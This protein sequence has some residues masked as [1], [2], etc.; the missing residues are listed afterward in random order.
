MAQPIPRVS[1]VIPTRNRQ[2]LLLRTLATVL[3]QEGVEIAVVVVD[4]ASSDGTPEALA[5][6]ADGRVS[7]VRHDVAQGV[8]AA[9]NA[10]LRE[11]RTE[12]VAFV[13][14]DD[15]WAP[16]KLA[17]QLA[18][19]AARPGSDW[20]CS[21]AV[22]VDAS[23]NI[24]GAEAVPAQAGLVERLLSYNAIPGGGSSVLARTETVRELGGF[25][26]QLSVVADWDLWIRLAQ[27]SPL[28]AANRPLVGYLR[29]AGSMS[30]RLEAIRNELEHVAAKHAGARSEHGLAFP[31]ERWLLWA[32]AM[33]RRAGN[34]LDPAGIYARLAWQ[35]RRPLLL[36]KAALAAVWP[37]WIDVRDRLAAE[38]V[39]EEWVAEAERWLGPLR[40]PEPALRG[41]AEAL[42]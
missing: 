28:A 2:A 5:S 36:A 38:E 16:D 11:V 31:W 37:G 13:D 22:V 30:R 7:V 35:R 15:V 39:P 10:G 17:A 8:A 14:D 19:L 4:E 32:A 41:E 42:A 1:V 9:R 29:H 26:P 27:R 23:L 33:H 24:V 34:R 40:A 25:D 6:L 20:S 21:G 12:W 18:A 3:A